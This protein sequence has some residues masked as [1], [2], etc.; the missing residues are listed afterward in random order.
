VTDTQPIVELRD[1]TFGFPPQGAARPVVEHIDLQVAADDYLGV[2]GPNGGGKTTLLRIMLGMLK[3]QH[4]EVRVFGHRP[5]DVRRRIG[6]VPQHAQIDATVP[7]TVLD[8]VLMGRLGLT[9]WGAW[10]GRSHRAA[11][12]RALERTETV[13]LAD[14]AIGDLSGGQRQ[15]V[16]I[17]RALAGEAELLLLDE[18]TAGVDVHMERGLNDLLHRINESMPIVLVSH[19]ISFVSTH[20]KRV[21]CLHRTLTCHEAHE[22]SD[23]VIS[24]MYHGE[25][26]LVHHEAACPLSDAGCDHGCDTAHLPAGRPAIAPGSEDERA[27]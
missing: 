24:E 1:V 25:V 21:A 5:C 22:I 13:E 4:G 23:E 6:Y 3:P 20:L 9:R 7:A 18:P 17:A 26:R 10:Y 16:L 2:I 15:R 8:I 11:A 19:D 14:R 12:M 27:G